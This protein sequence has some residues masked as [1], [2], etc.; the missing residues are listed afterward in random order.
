MTVT[1]NGGQTSVPG[2]TTVA[3]LVAARAGGSRG[4]AVALNGEVV[5]RSSWEA[6]A[7]SPGDSMELL[8]ATAGG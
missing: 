2:G 8:V 4:V 3:E 6:T 7:L 5:P 1:V